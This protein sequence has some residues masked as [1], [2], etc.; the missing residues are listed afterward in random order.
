MTR[1]LIFLLFSQFSISQIY[2][3]GATLGGSNFIGDVGGSTFINPA[4]VIKS[5]SVTN[6]LMTYGLT[7]KWNRSP[8]HSYRFSI[9]SSQL[10]AFDVES[11]D[12]RRQERGLSFES[13]LFELSMGMEFTFLD[14]NLHEPGTKFTPYM[15]SGVVYTQYDKQLFENNNIAKDE[16]K[17][18]SFG[19][20]LTLGIKYRFLDQL[21]LSA[22][23]SA[24]YMLTDNIDGSFSNDENMSNFGNINN[25]DWYML[26]LVNI[27]YTFGRKPCYCNYN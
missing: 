16:S 14:F 7:L 8:R 25:N 23:F 5:D 12:P 6:G 22:E 3:I 1:I 17:L 21:I 26:S 13:D 24:R 10:S 27:S 4:G 9:L 18:N 11:N 2:E 15:Y 20:P 19:I